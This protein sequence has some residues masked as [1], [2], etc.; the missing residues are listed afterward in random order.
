MKNKGFILLEIIIGLFFIG[1]IATTFL[2]ILTLSINNL[3]RVRDRDEMNYIGE[4][5]VEK[6]KS[7]SPQVKSIISELDIDGEVDYID[8]DFDTGK[9]SCKITKL[10]TSDS[11]LEFLVNVNNEEKGYNVLFKASLP[12]K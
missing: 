6:F 2:P 10:N 9:Y 5:V 4:M 8:D 12:R 1:I 11:L 7:R 3:N